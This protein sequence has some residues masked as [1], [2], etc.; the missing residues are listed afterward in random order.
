MNFHE[1]AL[2]LQV[3]LL[4]VGI[5]AHGQKAPESLRPFHEHMEQSFAKLRANIEEKYGKRVRRLH[6]FHQP[7]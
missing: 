3:P 7:L 5:K 1:F 2:S 4:E 6:I